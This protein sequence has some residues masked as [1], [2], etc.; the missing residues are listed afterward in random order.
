ME[1][2][3]GRVPRG[4]AWLAALAAVTY[5]SWVLGF[6]LRPGLDFVDGYVSELS[7][8]DQ[9]LHLVFSGGD[10]ITG[11]IMI[12]VSVYALVELRRRPWAVAGWSFL[13]AFGC[14]A[15]GDAVF[16]MDCAPSMDTACALRERAG[17]LS[18]S[19]AFHSVTSSMVIG[20]GI[21]A[22]LCLS[23]AARRYGWWPALARWG[24]LL[25]IVEAAAAGGTL[26]LMWAGRWLGLVQR[27][28]ITI[29]CLG[30]F[31][32]AWALWE[33]PKARATRPADDEAKAV[34]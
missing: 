26:V 12:G 17:R 34:L 24:W 21:A 7:A 33:R 6:L 3:P 20:C 8:T 5:S 14:W 16:S 18:F 13:L 27:I 29:L 30:L 11:V 23:V 2:E 1:D 10:L 4:V 32:I 25:A 9:P 19:H 28:Q 15:I 22:L 31:L